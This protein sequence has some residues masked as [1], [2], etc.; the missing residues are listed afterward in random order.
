MGYH[1]KIPENIEISYTSN[2]FKNYMST[3]LGFTDEDIVNEVMKLPLGSKLMLLAPI[4]QQK[5]GE[6]PFFY[7]RARYIMPAARQTK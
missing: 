4:V 5:K 1:R 3:E 6:F 7:F 2:N